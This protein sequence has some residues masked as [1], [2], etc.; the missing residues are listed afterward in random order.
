ML[1]IKKSTIILGLMLNIKHGELESNF[2]EHMLLI[3]DLPTKWSLINLK[4]TLD[5]FHGIKPFQWN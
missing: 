4:K 5:L 3:Q 1:Q 2:Q